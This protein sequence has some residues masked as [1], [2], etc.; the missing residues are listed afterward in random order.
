LGA[1]DWGVMSNADREV[2]GDIEWQLIRGLVM[3]CLERGSRNLAAWFIFSNRLLNALV[4]ALG[5]QQ[6]HTSGMTG[7]FFGVPLPKRHSEA[8]RVSLY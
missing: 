5:L 3:T 2:W 1:A 6:N 7:V 8:G 4:S